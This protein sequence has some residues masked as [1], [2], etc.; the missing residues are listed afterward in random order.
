MPREIK[1]RVW[2]KQFKRMKV[3]GIGINGG[4]IAGD[5]VEIM[6][7]T[8]LKDKNGK[9]I[10]EGDIVKAGEDVSQV[11]WNTRFASFCLIKDGWMFYHWFGEAQEAEESEVIGDIYRTPELL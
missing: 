10:Y 3:T 11:V 6:Q 9:D 1:F 5:D 8:G 7:Y 2:D 4:V